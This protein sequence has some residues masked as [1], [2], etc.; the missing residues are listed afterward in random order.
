MPF[1]IH[2][3]LD[4]CLIRCKL[5]LQYNL[6][7]HRL[8]IYWLLEGKQS[9][10][11]EARGGRK[12]RMTKANR[13]WEE[14]MESTSEGLIGVFCMQ[15]ERPCKQSTF[16][17]VF[18]ASGN[19][20]SS[21][22]SQRCINC[23]TIGFSGLTIW[24][25]EMLAPP[26]KTLSKLTLVNPWDETKGEEG[27]HVTCFFYIIKAGGK[28][29]NMLAA[30]KERHVFTITLRKIKFCCNLS[31]CAEKQPAVRHSVCVCSWKT[32]H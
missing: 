6:A 15:N 9:K 28:H 29:H 23:C 22:R 17:G 2:F 10:E 18:R 32:K 27:I 1:K 4:H 19:S 30:I 8:S 24:N 31:S 25:P 11:E 20:L 16:R 13:G 3:F 7:S 21:S 12:G 14:P 5:K 26:A